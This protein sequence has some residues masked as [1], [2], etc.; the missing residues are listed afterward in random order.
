MNLNYS[1]SC[2]RG[3]DFWNCCGKL[4]MM[5]EMKKSLPSAQGIQKGFCS[6]HCAALCYGLCALWGEG[7]VFFEKHPAFSTRTKVNKRQNERK[8]KKEKYLLT[9]RSTYGVRPVP[10]FLHLPFQHP[11]AAKFCMCG[12]DSPLLRSA[13]HKY[14]SL[15]CKKNRAKPLPN[16]SCVFL[17]GPRMT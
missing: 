8:K 13:V 9:P 2:E 7:F 5:H 6:Q 3:R 1:Y 16:L 11:R 15:C 4:W 10:C 12:A 17:P 14:L